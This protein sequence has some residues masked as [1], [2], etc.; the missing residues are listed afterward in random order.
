[1]SVRK[2]SEMDYLIIY[3]NDG[4]L[5]FE[6]SLEGLFLDVDDQVLSAGTLGNLEGDINIDQG[7]PP[8][9]RES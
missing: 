8:L 3:L 6:A 1:M 2:E 4:G 7:L 9:E 5:T